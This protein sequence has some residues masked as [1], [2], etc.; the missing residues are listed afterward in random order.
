MYFPTGPTEVTL[1]Q[2]LHTNVVRETQL[3]QCPQDI[4]YTDGSKREV[5]EFGTCTVTGSGVYRPAPPA[6]LKLK[7]HPVGQGMLNTVNRA[8]LAAVL[9]A[10]RECRQ[11]EDECIATN[12]RCS[13]QTS[14]KH[15]RAPAQTKDDCH[16]LL[17]ATSNPIVKQAKAGLITKTVKVKSHIQ[18]HGNEMADELANEVAE[19]CTKARQFDRDVSPEH[20]EPFKDKFWIQ[21]EVQVS[22]VDSLHRQGSQKS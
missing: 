15:L 20:C 21:Q 3:L 5:N 16:Q 4:I 22:I 7:V 13:L 19:K 6:A 10:L 17:L 2:S 11:H 12:S 8:E 1:Q 14:N 18:L 9:V